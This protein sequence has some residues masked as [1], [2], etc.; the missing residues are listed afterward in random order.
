MLFTHHT[1]KYTKVEW[2]QSGGQIRCAPLFH[3]L[4]T[5][6]IM[7][8]SSTDKNAFLGF[9]EPGRRLWNPS[10]FQDWGEP[11]WKGRLAP[12]VA[13]MRSKVSVTQSETV[14]HPYGLGYS[15]ICLGPVTSTT[16]QGIREEL[17]YPC[18]CWVI[19]LQ[20]LV[21]TTD[22]EVTHEP[23]SAPL[24]HSLGAPGGEA[25]KFSQIIDS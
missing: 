21:P 15:P 13:D 25:V 18:V 12:R 3:T 19:G 17:S 16:C 10:P 9:G 11:F 22:P 1:Q 6:T 14:L 23:T 7:R 20:N 24:S 4:W 8:H 5:T 2:C